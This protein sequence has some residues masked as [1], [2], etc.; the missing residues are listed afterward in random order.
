MPPLLSLH[1]RFLGLLTFIHYL[2]CGR[3]IACSTLLPVT[4]LGIFACC[5]GT[6][7]HYM[8]YIANS[9]RLYILLLK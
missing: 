8:T 1:G 4:W 6:L 3:R 9:S 2:P 5:G 7:F